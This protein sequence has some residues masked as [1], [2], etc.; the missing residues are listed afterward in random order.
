MNE[1]GDPPPVHDNPFGTEA[2]PPDLTAVGIRAYLEARMAG[3][4]EARRLHLT[5]QALALVEYYAAGS[6]PLVDTLCGWLFLLCQRDGST[7]VEPRLVH[8]A[9]FRCDLLGDPGG[10]AGIIPFPQGREAAAFLERERRIH[11]ASGQGTAEAASRRMDDEG[12]GAGPQDALVSGTDAGVP[13]HEP[14]PASEP[15]RGGEAQGGPARDPVLEPPQAAAGRGPGA[16]HRAARRAGRLHRALLGRWGGGLGCSRNHACAAR[17]A[18][19]RR[20]RVLARAVARHVGGGTAP[21]R[22]LRRAL[23]VVSVFL[24]GGVSLTIFMALSD[25]GPPGSAPPAPEV[26]SVQ[27]P[28][29]AVTREPPKARA[30]VGEL[31]ALAEV[32]YQE[33][34]LTTPAGDNA[35]ETYTAVLRLLPGHGPALDGLIRIRDRYRH[36]AEGVARRGEG[37][38]AAHYRAKAAEIEAFYRRQLA[39][40]GNTLTWAGCGVTKKAFM[41]ELAAAF[42]RQTGIRVLLE[43]GGATRGIR[44]TARG[45]V[46]F[47]GACRMALPLTD[48]AEMHVAL[49]PVAWDALA[50]ILH[51]SNPVG[52][53]SAAQLKAIYRGRIRNWKALG[54]PDA[55]IHLYVRRGKISGV[56]YAIRQ[57]IFQDR[58]VDFVTDKGR[59]MASSGPLEQ[60]V[61]RDPQA[62]GITGVSSARRR[63]VKIVGIDGHV[64]SYEN[65]RDGRYPL[66][67]PLYLVTPPSPAGAVQA[68]LDFAQSEQGR[69]IIRS[70]GTVPYADA[71]QLA[72][73]PLVHGFGV[74]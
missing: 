48:P 21:G 19:G 38:K 6:A 68:F 60:A 8:E 9:A 73:R 2:D 3:V 1:S 40:E 30:Q 33:K 70:Q 13:H 15:A 12:P 72:A 35:L 69:R 20:S 54:G 5:G 4:D 51:P 55:P 66:Y 42:Q 18:I 50:V 36:W 26:V 7:T 47:G 65:L 27:G 57:Y 24:L 62:M 56:G 22:S 37:A 61:E 67:R 10:R 34:R 25:Q 14:V 64:P 71:L 44:D 53:L 23:G 31:L 28:K 43:G 49:H 45:V 58:A 74:Q 59:V 52:R 29:G 11:A 17:E 39:A 41:A 32:Q 63:A 46:H 16:L